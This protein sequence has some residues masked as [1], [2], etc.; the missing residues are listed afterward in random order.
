M[1]DFFSLL[2]IDSSK[3]I[4]DQVVDAVGDNPEYFKMILDI[5]LYEKYPLAMRAGRAVALCNEKNPSFIV[6]YLDELIDKIAVSEID[7]VK[8][9]IMKAFCE[10][11]DLRQFNNLGKLVDLCFKWLLNPK[12]AVAVRYYSMEILYKT[13]KLEPA[14][15]NEFIAVLET[16]VD[17]PS[18]GLA[19]RARKIIRQL[20]NKPEC[21]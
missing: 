5:C 17:N 3:L 14:L 13:C 2:K 10:S 8:R 1:P 16:L 7:G 11:V 6:P 12:E 18:V 4:G 15:I 19:G 20:Q 9:G 21:F